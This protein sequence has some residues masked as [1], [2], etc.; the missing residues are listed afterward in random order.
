MSKSLAIFTIII[1]S[2]EGYAQEPVTVEDYQRAESF[3][4][5]NTRSLILN[6][7][8]SPNWLEDSRMWYRNTVKNG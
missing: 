7:N 8:V 4:S 3:L 6:A 5:A 1:F 2:I